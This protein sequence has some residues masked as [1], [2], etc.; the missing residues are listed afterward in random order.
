LKSLL[1]EG[2]M[3]DVCDCVEKKCM[4]TPPAQTGAVGLENYLCALAKQRLRMELTLSEGRRLRVLPDMIVIEDEIKKKFVSLNF[5]KFAKI[6][7]YLRDIDSDVEKLEK[8]HQIN[9]SYDIG[10]GWF[11]TM[12]AGFKRVDI[13]SWYYDTEDSSPLPTRNGIGLRFN[14]WKAFKKHVE[15]IHRERPDIAAVVPCYDGSD[16]FNQQGLFCF[17]L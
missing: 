3:S 4:V 2:K 16:H 7:S 13:R 8:F 5:Q 12:V 17:V 10:G 14:E 1:F 9:A 15:T 11:V 6:V